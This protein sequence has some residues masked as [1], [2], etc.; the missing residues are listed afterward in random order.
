MRHDLSLKG[1]AFGLRPVGVEDAAEIVALRRDPRGSSFINETSPVISDQIAWLERYFDRAGDWYFA[2]ESL[3]AGKVHGL[4]GVYDYDPLVKT[5]EWG[6]W[7]VREGST[8]AVESLWLVYRAAFEA[9]GL[10]AV[11]CRT[12]AENHRVV[13]LHD[14]SG[15][16]RSGRLSGSVKI[17]AATHDQIEH[18]ADRECWARMGPRLEQLARL[19][20]SRRKGTS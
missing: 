11:Y 2:I 16:L 3:G 1:Y 18:R 13:S 12:V 17:R 9:I 6:R 4:V 14:S 20:A 7:I 19:T 15:A 10:D 8:A 5:A